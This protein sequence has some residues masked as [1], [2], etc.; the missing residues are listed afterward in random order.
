[1]HNSLNVHYLSIHSMYQ[2]IRTDVRYSYS[3]GA[4]SHTV[5]AS[6]VGVHVHACTCSC[7]PPLT[8]QHPTIPNNPCHRHGDIQ[9]CNSHPGAIDDANEQW[10]TFTC[11]PFVHLTCSYPVKEANPRNVASVPAAIGKGGSGLLSTL[12]PRQPDAVR[13]MLL[14]YTLPSLAVL[15]GSSFSGREAPIRVF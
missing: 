2:W 12:P 10:T 15:R 7:A 4:W 3:S 8:T 9:A 6:C 1:M 13:V 11:R 5:P 14:L